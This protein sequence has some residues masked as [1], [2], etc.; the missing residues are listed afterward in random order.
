M[1]DQVVFLTIHSSSSEQMKLDQILICIN[2]LSG[3][4]L[5]IDWVEFII[6]STWYQLCEIPISWT[7]ID[8]LCVFLDNVFIQ[9]MFS[10]K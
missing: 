9:N 6:M 3:E 1:L 10:C 5:L 2:F 4:T 7:W 8:R